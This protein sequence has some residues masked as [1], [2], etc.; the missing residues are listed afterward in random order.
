MDVDGD[1]SSMDTNPTSI[2]LA[3]P[4]ADQDSLSLLAEEDTEMADD[5]KSLLSRRSQSQKGVRIDNHYYFEDD[6]P[7]LVQKK[8][9]KGLTDYQQAWQISDESEGGEDI[10][11]DGEEIEMDDAFDDGFEPRYNDGDQSE[12]A[13][14]ASEMHIDLSP[15]EEAKQYI[16]LSY[17]P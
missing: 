16:T 6:E 14:T 9:T 4:T 12:P 10:E 11:E 13:D 1:V 5:T 7:Q 3:I 8:N 2:V 15:E 17:P